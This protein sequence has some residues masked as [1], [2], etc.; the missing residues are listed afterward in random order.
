MVAQG[1]V[2]VV[3]HGLCALMAPA[4][5][6]AGLS[7]GG[8][9]L[10]LP[11]AWLALLSAGLDM[12][13]PADHG[14]AVNREATGAALLT[15]T[16]FPIMAALLL[17]ALA[18]MTAAPHAWWEW[19]GAA[20]AVGIS[21]GGVGIPAAHELVHRKEAWE[22]GLGV[23]IVSLVLYAHFRIEHVHGH[24]RTVGTTDDPATARFGHSLYRFM[25]ISVP[26]EVTSAWRLEVERLARRGVPLFHWRNRMLWYIALQ[27]GLVAGAYALFGTAGLLFFLGQAAVAILLLQ[28]T[29]YIEH[30]G[31]E[32]GRSPRGGWERIEPWHSWNSA[33]RM[34]NLA[35]FN[36]GLHAEHHRWP[37][38]AYPE[39]VDDRLARHLPFGYATMIGLA[40]VPPLWFRVMNPLVRAE[41]EAAPAAAE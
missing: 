6:F 1:G 19:L 9:W 14:R 7:L 26:G 35:T 34:T 37:G 8:P 10:F 4:L 40:L 41:A 18:V 21:I 38:K 16:I 20:T 24:H 33:H 28:A 15:W 22:R 5:A 13:L 12:A 11:L 27:A 31:L 32:R 39:L 25:T 29:A 23:A 17:Y 2:A 3:L 30:Y 36:L